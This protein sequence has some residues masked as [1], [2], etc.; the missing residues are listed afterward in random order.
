MKQH[1]AKKVTINIETVND[2][3]HTECSNCQDFNK[4]VH[5]IK[6]ECSV[7]IRRRKIQLL[8][9]TPS[10][11]TV[12]R[13]AQECNVSKYLVKKVRT[14]RKTRGILS[15]LLT[16]T[17]YFQVIGFFEHDEYSGLCVGN[18]FVSQNWWWVITQTKKTV[19]CQFNETLY[20]FQRETYNKDRNFKKVLIPPSMVHYCRKQ[21]C[22]QCMRLLNSPKCKTAFVFAKWVETKL[23]IIAI[24]YC[25]WHQFKRKVS[26]S[27]WAK[28]GR[29]C[30][31]I[32]YPW[33][34]SWS[35]GHGWRWS[36]YL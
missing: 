35:L 8:P 9:L 11:W 2:A 21:W 22:T 13:T 4:L 24:I 28:R 23:Y 25:M 36:Y 17:T 6:D 30:T 3:D 15:E 29:R 7:S 26:S 32:L 18:D 10:N 34:T 1:V 31:T 27:L 12:E 33:L 14:L 16:T 19:A 20:N 5:Y